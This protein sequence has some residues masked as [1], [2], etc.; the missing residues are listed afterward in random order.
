MI[1]LVQNDSNKNIPLLDGFHDDYVTEVVS[2]IYKFVTDPK[3]IISV[4]KG[5]I[6]CGVIII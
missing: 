5:R 6:S 3:K 2:I 1:L 4:S